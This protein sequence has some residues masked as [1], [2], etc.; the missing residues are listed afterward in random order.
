M[1]TFKAL[2]TVILLF[3]IINSTTLVKAEVLVERYGGVDRYDTA[4]KIARAG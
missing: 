2:F 3:L 4:I 1:K